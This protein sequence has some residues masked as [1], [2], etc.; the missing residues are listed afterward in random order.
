MKL[1]PKSGINQDFLKK[2]NFKNKKY[3]G[4]D[5]ICILKIG[6]SVVVSDKL[7]MMFEAE[8]T[9]LLHDRLYRSHFPL[10]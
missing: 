4:Y 1:N 10:F 3:L 5:I 2:K 6:A 9:A 8:N 7:E